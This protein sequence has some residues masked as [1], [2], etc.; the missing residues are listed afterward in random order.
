M[1]PGF[2][3]D[4]YLS[5]ILPVGLLQAAAFTGAATGVNLARDIEQGWFDRLL[6][7]P[8]PRSVVMSG[9]IA[10]AAFRVLLPVGTLLIVG[11]A[12]GLNWPGV[13][14]LLLALALTMTLAGAMACWASALALKFKSQ[15]A[16]PLMQ[17]TGFVLVFFTPAYTPFTLL[18]GWLQEVARLN[19]LTYTIDAVRQG[20][21]D[22]VTWHDTWPGV[23]SLAGLVVLFAA[24]ALRNVQKTAI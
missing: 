6:L 24:L 1:L 15:D 20:F 21:I 4:D 9:I 17:S 2:A 7:S 19:P 13:L 5:F 3:S 14:G 22:Q 11:F 23:L 10:S 8:V 16:A 12:L 18:A